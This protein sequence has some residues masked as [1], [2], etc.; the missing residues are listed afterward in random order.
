M[1]YVALTINFALMIIMP[2]L[3]GWWIAKRTGAGWRLFFIGAVTFILSQIG[4]IPFN[5]LVTRLVGWPP[6][7]MMDWSQLLPYALFLG[8][9][10]GVFEETARYIAY[11][12]PAREARRWGQGLMLGAGHGGIEAI[13]VGVLGAA[14]MIGLIY[15]ARSPQVQAALPADQAQLI[16]D[17]LQQLLATPWYGALLGAL[18]RVFALCAHLAMSLMV[19][20]VFVRKSWLWLA[21]AIAWHTLLNAVAVVAVIHWGPYVTEALL[22]VM[23]LLSVGIIFALRRSEPPAAVVDEPEPLPPPTAPLEPATPSTESLDRSRYI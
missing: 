18:E 7:D 6:A 14:N 23:A 9:S 17:A 11:R 10:A 16:N 3:L 2:I 12:R 1:I 21:A 4:H 22:G 5:M 19:M 13:L 20:Q 8:L 15:A